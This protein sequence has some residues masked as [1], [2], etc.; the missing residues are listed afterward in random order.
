LPAGDITP[1][2]ME[3]SGLRSSGKYTGTVQVGQADGQSKTATIHLLVKESWLVACVCIFGGVVIS[4]FIRLAVNRWQPQ[5]SRLQ[6]AGELN[7][8]LTR[9]EQAAEP[10]D[11]EEKPVLESF[12]E[13]W[14]TMNRQIN[15]SKFP[16][17]DAI[18]AE[19]GRK[20]TVFPEWLNT[21][22]RWKA[23]KPPGIVA[24]FKQ[25]LDAVRQ[26]L[27]GQSVD[28]ATTD[29]QRSELKEIDTEI[30][31]AVAADLRKC[32]DDFE[33]Q[34][35][36][37]RNL[38]STPANERKWLDDN[39]L[40]QLQ[41]ARDALGQGNLELY[42]QEFAQARGEY[43]LFLADELAARLAAFRRPI[44]FQAADKAV[45]WLQVTREVTALLARA[46]QQA[47][48]DPD[49]A[50]EHY[51]AAYTQYL[52]ALLAG[53]EDVVNATT[54]LID[55]NAKLLKDQKDGYRQRVFDWG[56]KLY[57]AER[58][59]KA[60][61]LQ[62]A[63]EFYQAA[64]SGLTALA[65][66]LEPTA[67]NVQ[68]GLVQGQPVDLRAAAD[69]A[70]GQSVTGPASEAI[71]RLVAQLWISPRLS[72]KQIMM[73]RLA[74][75]AALAFAAMVM[76]VLLGLKLLWA[77]DPTWGSADDLLTAVLWGLGLHQVSGAAFGG[78]QGL[79]DR[80]LTPADGKK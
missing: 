59:L 3:I 56:N 60:G 72:V 27:T 66:E 22:R 48:H 6:R 26:F 42:R 65:A 17:A 14:N 67:G 9:I 61:K 38:P 76:A 74:L 69:A 2:T 79:L 1:L 25:R 52:A 10:A 39:V 31:Q 46:R 8:E 18:D 23:V 53:A 32:L 45:D 29:A 7:D 15:D 47:T 63:F 43:V 80:F 54:K 77:S 33:T 57:D 21:Y 44:G 4:F 20:L 71:A 12:R 13:R 5:L 36:A 78:S 73:W 41:P 64:A 70:P 49:L 19:L 58:L 37:R 55:A 16:E 11:A 24:G 28:A 75:E 62:S 30:T 34:V 50:A 35:Q 40:N 51:Q 68:L